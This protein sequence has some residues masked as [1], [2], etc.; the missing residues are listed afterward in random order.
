MVTPNKN[1]DL[2]LAISKLPRPKLRVCVEQPELI[3]WTKP[4]FMS[5]PTELG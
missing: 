5:K 3:P 4:I 1:A 2:S